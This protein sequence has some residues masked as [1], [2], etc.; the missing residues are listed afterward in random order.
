MDSDKKIKRTMRT[1]SSLRILNLGLLQHILAEIS[2]Q[3]LGRAK[4]HL[5]TAE[6]CGQF[7]FHARDAEQARNVGGFGLY[8]DINVALGA[9]IGSQHGPE[10]GHTAD[11]SLPAKIRKLLLVNR[12]VR[13]QST[14]P[15]FLV[16][17]RRSPVI[18]ATCHIMR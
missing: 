8:K 17:L 4:I 3:I 10:Q 5:A 9:Q 12:Y 16:H 2:A 7:T 15:T 13:H 6:Q 14:F 11:V 18:G 1:S